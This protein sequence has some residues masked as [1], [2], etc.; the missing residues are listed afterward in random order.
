MLSDLDRL[1]HQDPDVFYIS[2]NQ[3]H[4][5]NHAQK[6]KKSNRISWLDVVLLIDRPYGV[7]IVLIRRIID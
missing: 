4:N 5:I 1:I 2:P 3:S 6:I 7:G